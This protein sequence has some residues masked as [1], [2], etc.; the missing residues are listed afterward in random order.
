M[1]WATLIVT[2]V[3]RKHALP[4][5]SYMQGKYLNPVLP[6]RQHEVFPILLGALWAIGFEL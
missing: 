1:V 5:V 3:G 2:G 4:G 6:L